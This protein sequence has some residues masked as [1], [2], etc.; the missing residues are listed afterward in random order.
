MEDL[1]LIP[2]GEFSLLELLISRAILIITLTSVLTLILRG[3]PDLSI[4][5]R[6]RA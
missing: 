5:P 6:R 3:D 1:D 2:E 4:D